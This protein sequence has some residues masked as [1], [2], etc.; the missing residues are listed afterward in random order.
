MPLTFHHLI[1]KKM[2]R[3]AWFKRHY[4]RDQLNEGILVCRLCHR[5]IHKRYDEMTL[6]KQFTTLTSLLSDPGLKNHFA[7]V[8]KQREQS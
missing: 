7:W 1:P 3:R 8:A 2:H 6:G 5:G 4:S